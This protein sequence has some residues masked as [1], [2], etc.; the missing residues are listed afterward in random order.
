MNPEMIQR[1]PEA[2]MTVAE[3]LEQWPACASVLVE[4]RMACAG[5]ELSA[6]ETLADA[7]RVY[8]LEEVK[9]LAAL[10]AVAAQ[11]PGDC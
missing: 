2:E 7:A 11:A 1:M 6:F 3:L 5:C 10:R 4:R 8:G 9:F